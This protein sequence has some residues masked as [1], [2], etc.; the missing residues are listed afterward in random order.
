MAAE[1]DFRADIEGLRAIA[2][3]GVLAFHAGVPHVMGGYVGVDVF[4]VISG[5][6]ITSLML[7]DRSTGGAGGFLAAFYARRIRRILP[8]ATVVIGV[9][10]V[11]AALVQNPIENA[12]TAADARGATLFYSNIRFAHHATDYFAAH[13]APSP[14]QQY[15]SLS[16]EEQF[17]LVWPLVFV[18]LCWF[19]RH[20]ASPRAVL[21]AGLAIVVA[22]SLGLSI[23]WMQHE[24]IR[25]FYSLPSRAWELGIGALIAVYAEDLAR[26]PSRVRIA[27]STLGLGAIA[28]TMIAYTPSTPFPGWS[29]LPPTLG[30][31][32]VIA[33]SCGAPSGG[34]LYRVL[35]SKPFQLVGRFSFSLYLWHW[36]LLVL[37]V[38]HVKWLYASWQS[39][40]LLMLLVALPAAVVTYYVI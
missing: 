10:L 18:G 4:Y 34:P 37:K 16:L 23:L 31:A 5:F 32:L 12:N 36:P 2:V 20:R 40:A 9:T 35:A 28:A 30:T 3:L 7:R 14:F 29:A 19:A 17:Y 24:P 13:D 21:G 6:L 8:A 27:M 33:A 38:E 22:G 39:R 11:G 26:I 15:W 25:A 1:R